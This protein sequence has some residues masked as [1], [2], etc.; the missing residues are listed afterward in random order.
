MY[1]KEQKRDNSPSFDASLHNAMSTWRETTLNKL[2]LVLAILNAVVTILQFFVSSHV[3]SIGESALVIFFALSLFALALLPKIPHR[4]KGIFLL[5]FIYIG[6]SNQLWTHGLASSALI[7]LVLIPPIAFLIFSPLAG[8]VSGIASTLLFII[9]AV[10]HQFEGIS[11]LMRVE[12]DPFA[13]SLWFEVGLSLFGMIGATLLILNQHYR[14]TL[15]AVKEER[16]QIQKTMQAQTATIFAM[17]K[18]AE[19]RDTDTGGHLERVMEYSRLLAEAM[20]SEVKYRDLIDKAFVE[21]IFRASALH[22]IGKI[23]IPD[24]ILR[25]SNKLSDDEFAVMKSH[26]TVGAEKLQAVNANYPDNHFLQ[27]GIRIALAHHE[28][29]N[30]KGYPYGLQGE[31]IPLEGRIVALVDVYDAL[32]SKRAYKKAFSHAKS[33]EIILSQQG[34]QFDPA[35]VRAFV[36]CENRFDEVSRKYPSDERQQTVQI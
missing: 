13:P 36:K 33:R 4:L 2:L 32:R 9:F 21:N 3:P 18:L 5:I 26:V 30:G 29:W 15:N 11:H 31:A 10:L 34:K 17:A 8:W 16:E 1:R 28:W 23:A 12:S 22:D 24:A 35:V 25:K 7:S 20:Q 19:F 27:M 6:V 14:L